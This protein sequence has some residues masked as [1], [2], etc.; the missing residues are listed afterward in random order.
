M[1]QCIII[2]ELLFWHQLILALFVVIA[3]DA[4]TVSAEYEGVTVFLK[5]FLFLDPLNFVFPLTI[6]E[7]FNVKFYFVLNL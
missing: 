1:S 2:L 3:I 6:F 5:I 7:L 4:K